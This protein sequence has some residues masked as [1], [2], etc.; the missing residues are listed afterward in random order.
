[1]KVEQPV[2]EE[3]V[4]EA[5]DETDDAPKLSKKARRRKNRLGIADLKQLVKRPDVV[6]VSCD[7]CHTCVSS[8]LDEWDVTHTR[9]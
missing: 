5:E 6:E 3:K 4:E 2:V 1:M 7:T 8:A 9:L